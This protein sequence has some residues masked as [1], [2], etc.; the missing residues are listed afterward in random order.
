MFKGISHIVVAVKDLD[1]QIANY[2]ALLGIK[3][4]DRREDPERGMQMA[5]F[6]FGE[7]HI[8]LVS[9]LGDHGPI[10]KRLAEHGEGT[11]LFGLRVDDLDATVE[12]L[13]DTS[14]RLA[15]DPGSS[16]GS[17]GM[18]L[19]HPSSAGGALIRLLE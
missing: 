7:T 5:F 16:Q 13:G 17:G 14:V 18:V 4:V 10:T 1:R 6:R 19:V 11:H 9:N 2:E 8:E 15:S 3:A 12:R